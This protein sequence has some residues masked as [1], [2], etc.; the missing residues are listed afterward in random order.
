MSSEAAPSRSRGLFAVSLVLPVV[1]ATG[2]GGKEA[3]DAGYGLAADGRCYP[4][5]DPENPPWGAESDT[6]SAS[7]GDGSGG[8][9]SGG[10]GSGGDGSSGDG[11]GGDVGGD[12]GGD[13]GGGDAGGDGGTPE[14][15]SVSGT[16]TINA[17]ADITTGDSV[18]IAV[19]QEVTIDGAFPSDL[20]VAEDSFTVPTVGAA[21]DFRLEL[22]TGVP[23]D[24]AEVWVAAV[25]DQ[26]DGDR[27]D[28]PF[29]EWSGNP[30]IL[31]PTDPVT[32]V[33]LV[34]E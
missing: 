2:C 34:F 23:P 21:T 27:S 15:P 6:A 7:G 13:P 4:I 16:F 22:S 1:L 9:G 20:P 24:G 28:D 10:D 8:D 33:E 14:L 25:L 12:P 19:W 5:Y 17:S 3:C 26:G 30:A 31:T 11:S 18:Y 29:A 32:G